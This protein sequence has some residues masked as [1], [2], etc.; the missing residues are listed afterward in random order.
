MAASAV[1]TTITLPEEL[2]KAADR[3]IAEGV[4]R[5]RNE[6]LAMALRDLLAARR[7][8]AIDAEFIGMEDDQE[9]QAESAL[10]EAGLDRSSWEAFR[11]AEMSNR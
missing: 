5:S 6:L 3:A 10:L 4:A 11:Q 2:L 7:R 9:Y 1:R 8:A